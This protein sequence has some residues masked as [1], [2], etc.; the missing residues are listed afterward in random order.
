MAETALSWHELEAPTVGAHLAAGQHLVRGWL[1]PK[2]A[3]VLCDVRVRIGP[4]TYGGVHGIPRADVAASFGVPR[5][6]AGFEVVATLEPADREITFETLEIDGRWTRFA[7][8]S[9]EVDAAL[10]RTTIDLP[11]PP[12]R[13]LDYTRIAE[14]VLRRG[15]QA[16]A[17]RWAEL[18]REL[19]ATVPRPRLARNAPPPLIGFIDEPV[20]LSRCRHGRLPVF[21]HLFHT[22]RRIRRVLATTDLQVLQPLDYGLPSPGP[23]AFYP[24]HANAIDCGFGGFVDVPS[25]LPG[26]LA[27]RLYAELEDGSLHLAHVVRTQ[28]IDTELDKR[29]LAATETDFIAALTALDEALNAVGAPVQ[30]D[31]EFARALAGLRTRTAI[32]IPRG[33]PHPA[34]TPAPTTLATPLPRR[35]LLATHALTPQGAP[36]FLLDLARHLAAAGVALHVVSAEGGVLAA[37]F[38]ALGARVTVVDLSAAHASG[39]FGPALSEIDFS[40]AD[41][42]VANTFTTF[43]A[44]HA[45]RAAGVPALLYIHE[46]TTPAEFYGAR[47]P[48]RVVTLAEEAIR[49]ADGVSFT[50]TSTARYHAGAHWLTPPWIDVG[51]IDRWRAAHTPELSRQRLGAGPGERLVCNIGTVSD[52]KGQHAFVRAVDLLWRRY[53]ELAATARFILLGARQTPFDDLL[54]RAVAA[55]DRPNI[56]LHPETADY[57]DYYHAADIFACSSYEES[58]P[59]VV[60][61]AMAFGAPI[62]AS[63]VQ[64]I[65]E[66]ARDGLEARLVPA[67]DTAAWCEALAGLLAEPSVGRDLAA[68]ARACAVKEFEASVVLPRHAALLA[69]VAGRPRVT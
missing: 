11:E 1:L 20:A 44:V 57:F 21:G 7:S 32:A 56:A 5:A 12:L 51:A 27:L 60:L 19:V 42:V 61:E 62:L 59:R 37:D 10:P 8:V 31:A 22:E 49:L 52:R 33:E 34:I 43:W 40:G 3:E 25:Q 35:A 30:R 38:A 2:S 67:G 26:P 13:W 15:S 18:A 47:V 68:R 54:T 48:A 69:Q 45:A 41:V 4:R 36:R 66:L 9:I 65:P 23:A 53:P 29:P 28:P 50:T 24:Q 63:A 6:L 64:G 46:S 14:T 16:P 39:A 17:P 55:I 58:S